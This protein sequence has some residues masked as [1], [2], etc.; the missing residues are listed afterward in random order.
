MA[1]DHTEC[2]IWYG[3]ISLG[4]VADTKLWEQERPLLAPSELFLGD[5]AYVKAVN[6][7]APFKRYA[8]GTLNAEQNAYNTAHSWYFC[9][10]I[11]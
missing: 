1:C 2:P 4:T 5:K 6:I 10:I 7:E 9:F 3:K 8:G 11:F